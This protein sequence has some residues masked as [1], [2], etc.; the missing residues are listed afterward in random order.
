MQIK[1]RTQDMPVRSTRVSPPHAKF[2]VFILLQPC[3]QVTVTGQEP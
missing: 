3:L 2:T 1:L